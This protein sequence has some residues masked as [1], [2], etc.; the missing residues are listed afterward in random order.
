MTMAHRINLIT[1]WISLI[2]LIFILFKFI[3]KRIKNKKLDTFF[4][5]K[6][7]IMSRYLI[8]FGIIH[9][10]FSFN[11]LGQ[12]SIWIYVFGFMCFIAMI[13][14]SKSIKLSNKIKMKWINHHRIFSL[15]SI[16][17]FLIHFF[18]SFY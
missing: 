2:C 12:I 3:T 7:K 16:I 8:I 18:M 15:I 9:G 1:A 14:T 4:M 6:H 11:K 13:I 10:I 17:T 5:K